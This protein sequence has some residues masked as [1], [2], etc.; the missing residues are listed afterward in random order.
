MKEEETREEVL[1]TA[2]Q[3]PH[4]RGND[5]PR[6]ESPLGRL[7]VLLGLSSDLYGAG[8][9][10]REIVLEAR[11][12]MGLPN[13]GWSAGKSGFTDGMDDK[14]VAERREKADKSQDESDAVL[15]RIA[16]GLPSLMKNLC[17]FEIDAI[18]SD[19]RHLVDGL[20]ELQALYSAGRK[21][22]C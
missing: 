19:H 18:R 2:L 12:A 10:Y 22:R 11:Q 17:V 9:R 21:K 6:L 4:R 14:Q 5:D 16:R 13:P 15:R 8:V 7:C 1:S 20:I 3:Q